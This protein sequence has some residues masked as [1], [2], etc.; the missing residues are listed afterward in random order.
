RPKTERRR[1]SFLF[2][3][4]KNSASINN[5]F[6][7]LPINHLIPFAVNA[8]ETSLSTPLLGNLMDRFSV[9]T[10]LRRHDGYA[11]KAP[12]FISWALGPQH[13][14]GG[15]RT[16]SAAQERADAFNKAQEEGRL[17][18]SNHRAIAAT[19]FLGTPKLH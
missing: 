13:T 2:G 5:A 17:P 9:V 7:A 3:K 10:S 15:Y 18:S 1:N 11:I 4:P 6:A 19:S 16:Q 12:P 14:F 8:T